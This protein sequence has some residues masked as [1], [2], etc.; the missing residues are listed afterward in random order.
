MSTQRFKSVAMSTLLPMSNISITS[1][2]A[3]DP[4]QARLTATSPFSYKTAD[5]CLSICK[6]ENKQ[7]L[8]RLNV[9]C[10]LTDAYNKNQANNMFYWAS[11]QI[12]CNSL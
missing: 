5:I 2:D 1:D 6:V 8:M 7:D 4:N 12:L 9:Y 3:F 10:I 11:H